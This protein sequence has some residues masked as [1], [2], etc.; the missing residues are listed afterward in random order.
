MAEA[1]A[2][3]V[4]RQAVRPISRAWLATASRALIASTT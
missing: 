2:L 1:D 3:I 4:A